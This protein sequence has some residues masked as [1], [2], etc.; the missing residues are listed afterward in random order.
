[1]HL[2]DALTVFCALL[3]NLSAN[4]AGEIVQLRT[5][6]HEVCAGLADFCTVHHQS[7]VGGLRVLASPLQ[8]VIHGGVKAHAVTAKTL[9]DT[10][11]QF[12]R[13]GFH[14]CEIWLSDRLLH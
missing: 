2:S 12:W 10:G 3:A 8:A 13:I 1:V 11:E 9:V 5:A 6:K 7:E 4:P 14:G